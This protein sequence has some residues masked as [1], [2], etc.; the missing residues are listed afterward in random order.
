MNITVLIEQVG[1]HKYRASTSHPVPMESEGQS[2]EEAVERLREQAAQRL[3]GCELIQT[4]VPGTT[5]SN[6]WIKYAGLWKDNPD[7]ESFLDNI[8]E[9]PRTVDEAH[10]DR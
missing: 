9:Y 10:Q 2:R 6:P 3:K 1:Q 8:A 4:T 5:D 7:F